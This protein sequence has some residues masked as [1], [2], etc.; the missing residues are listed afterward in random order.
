MD[1]LVIKRLQ[2]LH[3]A[4]TVFL[5]G[6]MMRNNLTPQCEASYLE[7]FKD[8]KEH[9]SFWLDGIFSSDGNYVLAERS[10]GILGSL[11]TIQRSRGDLLNAQQTVEVYT[12]VLKVYQGMCD[13]CTVQEQKDCC[14]VLTY[15]HDLVVS[16]TYHE[17]HLKNKCLPHFR[18]AVEYELRHDID[19]EGQNMAFMVPHMLGANNPKYS[20]L[21]IPKFRDVPDSKLWK[22]LMASLQ[23]SASGNVDTLPKVP[24]CLGCD[25]YEAIKG[26]FQNCSACKNALY[27]SVECQRKHWKLHKQECKGGTN[28]KSSSKNKENTAPKNK[29]PKAKANDNAS[30]TKETETTSPKPNVNVPEETLR[31]VADLL[32]HNFAITVVNHTKHIIAKAHIEDC[33]PRL[34]ERFKQLLVTNCAHLNSSLGFSDASH[35]LVFLQE[36]EEFF[37]QQPGYEK[38]EHILTS[39]KAHL[40]DHRKSLSSTATD[41]LRVDQEH[42]EGVAKQ[43]L[44]NVAK[45][46]LYAH[47]NLY[48]TKAQRKRACAG[49][50]DFVKDFIL[51]H[52]EYN[53]YLGVSRL[54]TEDPDGFKEKTN[55]LI[56]ELF[57]LPMKDED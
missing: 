39:Q 29:A 11:A 18:R 17:L 50:V 32:A 10:C 24:R 31:Q 53:S 27:C 33:Q 22:G 30:K 55:A 9:E 48:V 37:F 7:L 15:K 36:L 44:N 46:I 43:F 35:D 4:H 51:T 38:L 52:P 40:D 5:T 41:E 47:P 13:R 56:V 42:L 2:I 57:E 6:A 8:M 26:D 21:T 54:A 1:P 14:E 25:Y 16:N 45:N 20:P 19:I 49:Y 28:K 23:A 3:S 34:V 12:T